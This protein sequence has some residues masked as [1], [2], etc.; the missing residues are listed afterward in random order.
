[1][2]ESENL[3]S[4]EEL[5]ALTAGLFDGSI[6]ADTGINSEINALR[7]DLTNEDS[8]LGVNVGAID[9]IGIRCYECMCHL[10]S[11][12]RLIIMKKLSQVIEF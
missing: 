1:M 12:H 7:H 4:K 2:A 8:S 11:N 6:E 3:L 9:M 10:H 5:D